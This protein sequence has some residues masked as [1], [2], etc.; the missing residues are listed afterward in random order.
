M[1]SVNWDI[2]HHFP[3]AGSTPLHYAACGGNAQCCLV[4]FQFPFSLFPLCSL[5]CYC[6]LNFIFRCICS[7]IYHLIH[8][9]FRFWLLGVPVW[10]LKMPMGMYM[11]YLRL[12]CFWIHSN[13]L[14]LFYLVVY[15]LFISNLHLKVAY[16]EV[17]KQFDSVG[18][19]RH[20]RCKRL[21]WLVF[22]GQSRLGALHDMLA[23]VMYSNKY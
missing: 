21:F 4:C 11:I 9:A 3:G 1:S 5:F 23:N 17:N 19:R 7:G 18:A 20:H 14:V 15:L 22:C 2:C 12:I 8:A 16:A 6:I 13:S 10:L